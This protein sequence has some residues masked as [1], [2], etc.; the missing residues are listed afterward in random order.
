MKIVYLVR[1]AKS[2]WESGVTKDFDRPLN[3]RGI[4]NAAAMSAK[5]FEKGITVDRLITSPAKRALTT[6]KTFAKQFGIKEKDIQLD[7]NIYEASL[8]T[9]SEAVKQFDDTVDSV[10]LVGHNPGLTSLAISLGGIVDSLPTCAVVALSF[11]VEHWAEVE[12]GKMLFYDYPKKELR[13][14]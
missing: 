12:K 5:L 7:E 3:D 2:S 6:A 9:L 4:R 10:M 13:D 8:K 14:K 1:H 11:D